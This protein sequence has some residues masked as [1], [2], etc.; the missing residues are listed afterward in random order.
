MA[1][2]GKKAAEGA[3]LPVNNPAPDVA[4]RDSETLNTPDE[5]KNASILV[6]CAWPHGTFT[7]EGVPVITAQGTHLTKTQF[8]QAEKAAEASGVTLVEVKNA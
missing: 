8:N 3:A 2:T 4:R 1:E 5:S 6:K 7:V